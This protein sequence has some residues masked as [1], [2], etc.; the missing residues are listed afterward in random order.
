M[1]LITS[2]RVKVAYGMAIQVE[3]DQRYHCMS[4]L[5]QYLK[6]EV[7]QVCQD[8][9]DLELDIPGGDRETKVGKTFHYI[10]LWSKRY[11]VLPRR[12]AASFRTSPLLQPDP[13]PQPFPP[14]PP[15]PRF[16]PSPLSPPPQPAAPSQERSCSTPLTPSKYT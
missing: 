15:Q 3:Q 13:Q 7:E 2:F 5:P 12:V 9:E 1:L 10:I 14:S 6:V 11:I 16:A 8:F 4:I